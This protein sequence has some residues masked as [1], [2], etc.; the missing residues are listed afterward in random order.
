MNQ[1]KFKAVLDTS[2]SQA[3]DM[4]REALAESGFGVITEINVTETLRKKL[5]V[6]DFKDY[7]ILGACNPKMAYQALQANDDV[8][9]LLPCN[10]VVYGGEDV[11]IVSSIR[12]SHMLSLIGDKHVCAV[13]EEVD[14][15]ME[16]VFDKLNK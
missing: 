16:A 9:L 11:A 7:I 13:G 10:V 15:L 3:V 8:G 6:E 5:E 2:Y 12:P 4:V 1:M 14:K